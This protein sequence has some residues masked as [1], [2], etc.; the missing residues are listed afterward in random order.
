MRVAL[1]AAT[2]F[3]ASAA[4]AVSD[5]ALLP[6]PDAAS[7]FAPV[8]QPRVFT[9]SAL[10]G[11][12]DGGAEIFFEFGFEAA[13]VQ[14]YTCLDESLEVELYGMTD[15]TAALGIYLQRCGG[16]CDAPGRRDQISR[17]AT[18]GRSQL[19]FA[20]DRFFV[21]IT[22]EE[23]HPRTDAALE[24]LAVVISN[25][26]AADARRRSRPDSFT[27]PALGLSPGWSP[28]S[29][30]LIRGPL[31]LQAIITLG[32]GDVLQLR[33]R[34]TATAAE[35]P[36]A[37]G[38]PAHTLVVAAYPDE[39]AARAAFAHLRAGLDP[40]IT[41]IREAGASFVFRDY[42]GKFG[43]A[44]TVATRVELRLNMKADPG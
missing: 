26:L 6:P 43:S 16:R 36:D 18:F 42:A 4:L 13:T 9:G 3:L 44:V 28:G 7:G 15:P 10:Y 39:T 34:V 33:G 22:A 37:P 20:K 11:H 1:A 38:S 19:T 41:V 35:Y 21:V 25:R 31:A 2:L 17:Y 14:R 32:D 23:V 5:A 8:G 40:E 27:D 24:T 12:I 30:R 29:V